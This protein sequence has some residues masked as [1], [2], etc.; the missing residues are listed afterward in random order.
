MKEGFQYLPYTK[1]IMN[2]RYIGGRF[3]HPRNPSF[4]QTDGSF[5]RN[6]GRAA[7]ILYHD[8]ERFSNLVKMQKAKD[9]YE[10][11]WF[12]VY[13]GLLFAIEKNATSIE[14]ENDNLSVVHI[15]TGQ[16]SKRNGIA[17]HYEDKIQ[18]LAKHTEYTGIRWIPRKYNRADDLFHK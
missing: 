14:I 15:L 1:E 10:T 9:S 4:M 2:F 7:V 13:N 17:T 11:E 3:L 12:S 16:T 5:K 18:Q 6:V 8:K